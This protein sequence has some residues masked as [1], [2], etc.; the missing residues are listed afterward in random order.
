M[1]DTFMDNHR[2]VKESKRSGTGSDVYK[3]KW[4][5]Y[6]VLSFLI[7]TAQQSDSI[8]TM[9]SQCT[10]STSTAS[11]L[12]NMYY[13]DNVQVSYTFDCIIIVCQ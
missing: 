6:D 5:L 10:Q 12:T 9:D 8:S 7:K 4:P 13:D 2:K 1:R 3:P 11:P